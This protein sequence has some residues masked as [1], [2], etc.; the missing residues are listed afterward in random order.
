[1]KLTPFQKKA[2]GVSGKHVLISAGAGTGKTRVLVERIFKLVT[3]DAVP[4]AD[5]LVL[6]FTEKAA[7]EIKFR[8]SKRFLEEKR[9]QARQALEAASVSTFHG[10]AAKLLREHPVE[11]GVD[12][13]FRI[14]ENE[15]SEILKEEALDDSVTELFET[16]HSAFQFYETY[17]EFPVREAISAIYSIAQ[18]E[19]L[20]LKDYF[21]KWKK[22]R[23]EKTENFRKEIPCRAEGIT[24]PVL[25]HID[26]AAWKNWIEKGLKSW[27]EIAAFEAWM[28]DYS[29]SPKRNLQADWSA[30]KD[31]AE[32]WKTFQIEN[33]VE[34][35]LVV[36]EQA[37]LH[38]EVLYAQKK[39][40]GSGLDFDDLQV[41]AVS[42]LKEK[43]PAAQLVLNALQRQYRHV[44]VDEFQDTSFLQME[45]VS[46]LMPRAETFLVG[47]YKQSIYAF[48][49]AEPQLFLETQK[50]FSGLETAETISLTDNF[51]SRAPVLD[52]VNAFFSRL[53]EED[54]FPFEAL[55]KKKENDEMEMGKPELITILTG[56]EEGKE[57]ARLRE[58]TAIAS[59]IRELQA[60]GIP[61][62]DMVV[63]F[64]AMT[65]SVLYEYSFRK[66]EIPYISVSGISFYHQPEIRDLI[67]F[68]DCLQ[69]PLSDVALAALFRS[70]MVQVSDETLF[71]LAET[72]KS[73]NEKN[74]LFEGWTQFR[75][76]KEIADSEKQKLESFGNL[77]QIWRERK[78]T[79]RLS[80]LL[81]EAVEKTGY[82]VWALA[83]P[84]GVRKYSHI[85]KLIQLARRQESRGKLSIHSF[86]SRLRRL[87]FQEVRE[88]DAAVM[89]KSI[90]AVRLM[91]VHAAKGLEFPVVFLAD[92]GRD[93]NQQQS[94]PVL[95]VP[96]QGF[97]LKVKN[98]LTGKNESGWL[99]NQL[100]EARKRREDAERKRLFYVA[101]TRAENKLI[102]SGVWDKP[103]TEKETYAEMPSWMD[104][105]MRSRDLLEEKQTEEKTFVSQHV[106]QASAEKPKFQA[107]LD[108][109]AAG[110]E[111]SPFD[112]KESEAAKWV[113]SQIQLVEPPEFSKVV[114]LPVSA[115][116]LFSKNP[117]QF[118]DI[119]GRGWS[120]PE[121]EAFEQTS[122]ESGM[123]SEDAADFGTRMHRALEYLDWS[124]PGEALSET[125]LQPIFAG[126]SQ[127][128]IHEA[129]QI[130]K[131][132]FDTGLF[133]DIRRSPLVRRELNFVLNAR[134]GLIDG[135][136]D[137]LF[138]NQDGSFTVLDYK[139]SEGDAAKSKKQGYD[140]QIQIYALAAAKI[141]KQPVTRGQIYFLKNHSTVDV[142]LDDF[143]KIETEVNE[144]QLRLLEFV[145]S[146]WNG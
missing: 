69:N 2:V 21:L 5:I 28:S 85:R 54:Q 94:H 86:L 113:M 95:A 33:L 116:V 139:T 20:A 142:P 127:E 108:Q 141:L 103:K 70:P 51:R 46:L 67:S 29:R 66:L 47:D 10:F 100:R 57:A 13:D 82:A 59:R 129:A 41:R 132:F 75:E 123:K 48:R 121:W 32:E 43:T 3:A 22:E 101:V 143:A 134:R 117:G 91:T 128:K 126:F 30:W 71:W 45:F 26:V 104:W 17:G 62:G 124:R 90:Q 73:Q 111:I 122:A 87:Q 133:Q 15:E 56:E 110:Q 125:K 144:L 88:A 52:F 146:K 34:E 136:I 130:L 99:F 50:I 98:P 92:L 65:N 23:T 31:F 138:Q 97:A 6:T 18:Q 77:F 145:K 114:D 60:Q 119:Y 53:W 83:Q 118:W 72:A 40:A 63:L 24:A 38:F 19:G 4:L 80:D 42:L 120:S 39:Q 37:A 44:F 112:E 96:H 36:F 106:V 14:L 76:I 16:N 115:Y 55:Q 35:A 140:L 79:S 131:E 11:F 64:S 81:E 107:L 1:M 137:V 49:G 7:G 9:T 135:V 8:L 89:D 68:L 74:P 27:P 25:E 105:M 61:Y 78:D 109:A 84:G 102:L 93:R 58:G 12:P